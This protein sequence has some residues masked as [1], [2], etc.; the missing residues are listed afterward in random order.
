MLIGQLGQNVG[1]NFALAKC[2]FI[3]TKAKA[4]QPTANVHGRIL[5]G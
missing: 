1:V 4:A 2:G 3:L 5:T